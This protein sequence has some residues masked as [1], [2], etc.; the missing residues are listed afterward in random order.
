MRQNQAK[1]TTPSKS[2]LGYPK[3]DFEGVVKQINL[4]YF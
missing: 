4:V 3:K 1:I 2:F